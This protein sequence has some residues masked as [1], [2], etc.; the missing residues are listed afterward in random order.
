MSSTPSCS[1]PLLCLLYALTT[2]CVQH[3]PVLYPFSDYWIHWLQSMFNAILFCTPSLSTVCIDYRVCSTPS[4]S[5]PLLCLLYTLTTE[6]V[7]HH[8]VLYPFSVYCIHWLQSVFNA[9]L[10]CT[11]S[12]STGYIDYRVCSTLLCSSCTPFSGYWI[13]D[14]R[15]FS[16]P[17]CYVHPSSSIVYRW[18]L[19]IWHRH[20]LRLLLRLLYTSGYRAC[21]FMTV[22]WSLSPSSSVVYHWLQR[23]FKTAFCSFYRPAEAAVASNLTVILSWQMKRR[24]GRRII[25]TDCRVCS[26]RIVDIVT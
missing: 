20:S 8:P 19:S 15:V 22:S 24:R 5:V 16:T 11:P 2:E 7:Q 14:C 17:F 9:I 26:R 13:T 21:M 23:L 4:C 25:T 10:F 6:C 1:V 3:H 12:L 18:L